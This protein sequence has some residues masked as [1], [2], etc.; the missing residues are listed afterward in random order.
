MNFFVPRLKI[1]IKCFICA[2]LGKVCS[3]LRR[4]SVGTVG[5][6]FVSAFFSLKTL[7]K[8]RCR[9]RRMVRRFAFCFK[10]VTI[11]ALLIKQTPVSLFI[12]LQ[13]TIRHLVTFFTLKETKEPRGQ[14]ENVTTSIP[15]C[16]FLYKSNDEVPFPPRS[17]HCYN[18][19]KVSPFSWRMVIAERKVRKFDPLEYTREHACPYPSP[20]RIPRVRGNWFHGESRLIGV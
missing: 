4:P 17:S 20:W 2:G 16:P 18:F 10:S 1:A 12:G 6:N 13:D 19:G 5:S 3:E 7:K 15:Y 11:S 8:V 14:K 9:R